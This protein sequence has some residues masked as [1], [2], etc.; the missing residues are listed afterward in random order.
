MADLENLDDAFDHAFDEDRK[1]IGESESRTAMVE[2]T[3]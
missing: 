3:E 1:T 2:Q